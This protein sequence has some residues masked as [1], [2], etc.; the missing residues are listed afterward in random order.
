MARVLLSGSAKKAWWQ[1]P[2]SRVSPRNSTPRDSSSVLAASKSSTWNSIGWL[3]ARN[4]MPKASDCITAIVRFP[5]LELTGGHVPPPLR[6]LEPQR[7]A[8]E[9]RRPLVVLSGDG[10]E[11]GAA[12]YPGLSCHAFPSS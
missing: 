2:E 4:S 10:D 12:D 3:L 6:E 9:P 11:I 5:G 7:L 1:T 8:V